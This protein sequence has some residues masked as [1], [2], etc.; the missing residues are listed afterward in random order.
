[1][2]NGRPLGS[3]RCQS[4]GFQGLIEKEPITKSP[5]LHPAAPVE[6]PFPSPSPPQKVLLTSHLPT[7]TS[8]A[9]P[10]RSSLVT[11]CLLEPRLIRHRHPPRT[12]P[13]LL[14]STAKMEFRTAALIMPTGLP[15]HAILSLFPHWMPPLTSTPPQGPLVGSAM[16][17]GR[18]THSKR[19]RL[20]VCPIMLKKMLPPLPSTAKIENIHFIW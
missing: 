1:M 10:G 12:G 6:D 18:S 7:P 20:V 9:S 11:K 5:F 14:K 19:A 17:L 3:K 2:E 15:I 13:Y 4:K 8:S 16:P